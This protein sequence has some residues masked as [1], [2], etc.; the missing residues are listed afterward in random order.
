MKTFSGNKLLGFNE[1]VSHV[2]NE[3][4]VGIIQCLVYCIS[5]GLRGHKGRK[6]VLHCIFVV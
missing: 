4:R 5:A 1:D 3:L 6:A 2:L